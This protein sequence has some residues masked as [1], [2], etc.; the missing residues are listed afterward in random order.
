MKNYLIL[1][2]LF[3]SSML[4]AQSQECGT[5]P[6][7]GEMDY[8]D[9]SQ[10]DRDGFSFDPANMD[11]IQIPI[12]NHIVRRSNSTGGLT[13]G[14]L[15]TAIQNLNTFYAQ[16]NIEFVE[17]ESVKF[18]NSDTWY[19]FNSSQD[20]AITSANSIPNVLNI[21]YFNG[22]VSSSGLNLYGYASFPPRP[23]RIM[24]KNSCTTS[25]IILIHEVGHYFS[26]YHTHGTSNCGTTDELVNGSNCSTSGDRVCDTPADPN[27]YYNCS[28]SLVDGNC[29]YTG[30]YTD[31][32]GQQYNPQT[33]NIMSYS[34]GTCRSMFTPQQF[35]RAV[36]SAMNDRSYLFCAGGGSNEP[37]LIIS[38]KSTSSTNAACG[39]YS[40]Q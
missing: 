31:A 17:C 22:L 2:I 29:M 13:T 7:Q 15:A 11:V 1:I 36:Y 23:D 12:V 32:N 10:A 25:G 8:L 39:S 5:V 21:Y 19:D 26:L 30:N 18:I 3:A 35:N 33:N 9:N 24:M 38:A 6:T 14:Q 20:G 4:N 34:L 37:D 40:S 28:T 27:L 16:A